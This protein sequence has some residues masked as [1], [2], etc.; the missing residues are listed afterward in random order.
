MEEETTKI[1]EYNEDGK[2]TVLVLGNGFDI[3]LGRK[4]CYKDF[5]NSTLWPFGPEYEKEL[6]LGN[7]LLQR[8]NNEYRI[9]RW[10][11]LE[12]E[13][14][15][16]C[17]SGDSCLAHFEKLD[18]HLDK[19]RLLENDKKAYELLCSHVSEYIRCVQEDT[20]PGLEMSDA[21]RVISAL[22]DRIK[23]IFS[24][25]YT[26]FKH[27]ETQI[28]VFPNFESQQSVVYIH[29]KVDDNTAILGI[30]DQLEINNDYRFMVKQFNKN[31][32]RVNVNKDSNS[33]E[34]ALREAVNI[35]FFGCSFGLNDINYFKSFFS[36]LKDLKKLKS[37]TIFTYD[38]K[39]RLEILD[40]LARI[41]GKN[42][43]SVKYLGL[44]NDFQIITTK[45]NKN[46]IN[47]YI[48]KASY[49][50]TR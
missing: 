31:F 3:S 7:Y 43:T 2:D 16:Y 45:Y 5:C 10:I 33:I 11:D 36:E 40:T 30:D 38:N 21:A 12:E 27:L 42:N 15:K 34:N 29:G 9:D 41:Q 49:V 1:E 37:I 35:V 20:I 14:F 22:S 28:N 46:E 17:K 50:R 6:G 44:Y 39:S 32:F 23:R 26:N 25:N 18:S 47:K 13:L 8:K 4:T 48:K 24:F 19:E